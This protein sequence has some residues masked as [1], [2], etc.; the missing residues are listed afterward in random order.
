MVKWRGVGDPGWTH[1][2]RQTCVSLPL[3]PPQ[4]LFVFVNVFSI[5]WYDTA[6]PL[7]TKPHWKHMKHKQIYKETNIPSILQPLQS[8]IISPCWKHVHKQHQPPPHIFLLRTHLKTHKQ[9][10]FLSYPYCCSH[11]CQS[12]FQL[13]YFLHNHDN[14]NIGDHD[15]NL[16]LWWWRFGDD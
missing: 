12:H 4:P 5:R 10:C 11:L 7:S 6:N 14:F 1:D 3:Q 13:Q 2:W 8:L 9:G 15:A 16:T